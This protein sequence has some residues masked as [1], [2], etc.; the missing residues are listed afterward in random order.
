MSKA[1]T[2]A[3]IGALRLFQ[4]THGRSWKLQLSEAWENGTD[5]EEPQGEALRQLRDEFGPKWLL[6]FDPG[7]AP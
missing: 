3:Q 5:L 7:T 1:P 6:L 4:Q 2:Q